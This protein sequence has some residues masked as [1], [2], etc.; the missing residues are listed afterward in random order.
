MTIA[1]LMATCVLFVGLRLDGRRLPADGA[2]R[3]R[4]GL[5]RRS[6]RRRDEPGPEDRLPRRRHAARAADRAAD[7]RGRRGA[8]HRRHDQGAR[9][10]ARGP[11]DRP[12]VHAIGDK[13][14]APQGTLMATLIRGLLAHNLDWQFVLVGVFLAVTM[15]MC[16]V[17]SL[18]FAV[19]A[20]LPLSTTLPIFVGGLIR[21]F[22][23]MTRRR[24]P[25]SS[26][27]RRRRR[28]RAGEPLLDRARRRRGASAA[29][30]TRC[31]PRGWRRRSR[32]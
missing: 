10:R 32:R 16:G 27:G 18:A 24:R 7:R 12:V 1:T 8:R 31:S 17:R 28:A 23:E 4:D 19:G 6:E 3:G 5:H 29:S 15:E 20:Y 2:L 30:S 22:A 9:Q 26:G 13:F 14:P 11:G 25:A 21:H